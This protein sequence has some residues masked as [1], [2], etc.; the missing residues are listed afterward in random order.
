MDKQ[1][2][3]TQNWLTSKEAQKALKISGCVLMHRRESGKLQFKNIGRA[4][5]YYIDTHSIRT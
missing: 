2:E 4:F 5:M 3:N 1:N